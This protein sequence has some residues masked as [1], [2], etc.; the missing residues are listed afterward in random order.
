MLR[1][2]D[3]L[4]ARFLV[5]RNYLDRTLDRFA[6][7]DFF[8]SPGTGIKTVAEQILE[9]ADKDRESVL[10]IQ[11]GKWPD[12]EPPSFD[13]ATSSLSTA[14]SRLAEIR[15]T[16]LA[17]LDCLTEAQ[18]ESPML[19]PEGWLESLGLPECPVSEVLR[20]IAAH[21][22]YHAGQLVTYRLLLGDVSEDW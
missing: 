20:N 21:E 11:T 19:C 4:R 17:F 15:T 5:V 7:D 3:L 14:R 6:E 9:I 8:W 10:W 13:L 12:D 16:T 22:W 18:L 1:T 2:N